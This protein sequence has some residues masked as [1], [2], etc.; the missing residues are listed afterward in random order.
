MK[1]NYQRLVL[2]NL[3]AGVIP[4]IFSP[5][6]W[7][8]VVLAMEGEFPNWSTYPMATFTIILFALVVGIFGCMIIGMPTILILQKFNMN[9]PMVASVIGFISTMTLYLCFGPS[10]E[11]APIK[12]SWPIYLFLGVIGASCGYMA[13]YLSRPNKRMQSDRPT[14]GA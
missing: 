9:I 1:G 14:A 13:S 3:K 7:P 11:L 6:V 10:L 12:Q 4:A 2:A 5:I 8:F